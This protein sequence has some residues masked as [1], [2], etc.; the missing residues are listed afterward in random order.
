M[1]LILGFLTLGQRYLNKKRSK[2]NKATSVDSL[3]ANTSA[4]LILLICSFFGFP[5]SCTHL[6]VPAIYYLRR[7]RKN[8]GIVARHAM[9]GVALSV[10]M[11][12]ISAG[13][14]ICVTFLFL[15]L[16]YKW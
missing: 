14:A 6:L 5:V 16:N 12:M 11:I 3:I 15:T 9:F 8:K 1:A 10:A 4:S 2:Y 13:V 7:K